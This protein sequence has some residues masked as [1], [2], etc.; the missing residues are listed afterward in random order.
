MKKYNDLVR[1]T[2]EKIKQRQADQAEVYL[3]ASKT[4]KI[5]VINQQ[6]ESADE[7]AETGMALRLI[8][9]QRLGFSFTSDL[10]ESVIE[11]TID[12][13]L[14]SLPFSA[15]DEF[16]RLP[17]PQEKKSD[18]V[19]YDPK[20]A[21]APVQKKIEIALSMERAA[22]KDPRVKKTEKVSYTDSEHEIWIA[23]SQGME[24]NYRSNYCGGYADVIALEKEEMESGSGMDFVTTLEALQ[25]DK[26][27]SEASERATQL[28]G[29][30]SIPS[31][32]LPLV[33]DPLVGSQLL[34]ILAQALS[35]EAVQKG[36]SLFAQR[37]GQLIATENLNVI[38]NGRLPAGIASS[39]YDAEGVPTQ[40]TKLIEKGKLLNFLFNSY[41]GAKSGV[42][43]TGNAIRPS[44]RTPPAVGHTNLYFSSGPT[45]PQA[46][47]SSLKR[48]LY[49]TRIM[50]AHTAN[51]I[52]GD[53][54]FG[55]AGCLIE[56]GEKTFPVRGITIAGNL[57]DLLKKIEAVGADLRFFADIGSPT[58]LIA[59]LSISGA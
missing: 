45:D 15:Q 1:A 59:D 52:S 57:I 9:D 28:L 21:Q 2:L 25:P 29:A 20:I 36:R 30:R 55:A 58:M 56:N 49:I 37:I 11:E 48:G 39:L 16:L 4:L 13:A 22:Y 26:I 40:E 5:D 34:E 33:F 18:L 44:Y 6:I 38:D 8:K 14:A 3:V 12:L 10:D 35:S 41:T 46:I 50:G 19:L 51:P 7:M 42:A 24:I 17:A 54:S 47:I 27:G 23:N 53:F 32:N 43:S 31:Q